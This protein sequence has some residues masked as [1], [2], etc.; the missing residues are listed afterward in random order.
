MSV[1]VNGLSFSYGRHPVLHNISFHV[2][3][4]RM[5][6]VLG[7]NG[8]GKSTLFKNILGLYPAPEKTVFVNGK[9]VSSMSIRER[10]AEMAYI[11]QSHSPSFNY[12]VYDM[13]LMGTAAQVKLQSAPGTAQ[14]HKTEDM[15]KRLGVWTLRTRGFLQISGG[16]QQLVCIARALVQ[17][18]RVLIMDEPTANLDY[19]N[20]VLVQSRL[21]ELAG[22]GYTV[23]QSTHNPEQAFLYA[24]DVLALMDGNV[25]AFGSPQEVISTELMKK[26][27]RVDVRMESLYQDRI[28]VC[29][30][31][32]V[33]QNK[34]RRENS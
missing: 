30:P 18:A 26:L 32:S 1:K 9:D 12:S 31:T 11:P 15:M 17:G 22:E 29:I 2:D 14:R 28:R 7:P 20:Q 10:A 5:L 27:Y 25:E 3:S 34:K 16:E 21:S 13:V 23:I 19:G 8:V 4:G 6:S 33:I 24:D